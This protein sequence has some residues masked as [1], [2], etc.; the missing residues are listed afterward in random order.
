MRDQNDINTNE[1]PGYAPENHAWSTFEIHADEQGIGDHIDDW[2]PDW[3]TWCCGY[4]AAM[5]GL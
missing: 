5:N 1:H 4:N 2:W 3:V